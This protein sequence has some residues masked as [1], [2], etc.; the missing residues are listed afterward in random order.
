MV[1]TVLVDRAVSKGVR[2][3]RVR[4]AWR[5]LE[6][7]VHW[8]RGS[9]RRDLSQRLDRRRR[10]NV[11]VLKVLEIVN[12]DGLSGLGEDTMVVWSGRLVEWSV[13]GRS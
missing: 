5:G 3:T 4:V 13:L 10:G 11:V 7:L 9:T 1:V 2:V 8:R 12:W 6:R